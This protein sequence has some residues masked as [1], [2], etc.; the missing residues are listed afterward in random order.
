MMRAGAL[1]LLLSG[2]GWAGDDRPRSPQQAEAWKALDRE[3]A[4]VAKKQE[5]QVRA[6][7]RRILVALQEGDLEVLVD[8]CVMYSANAKERR[9]LTR[10][11]FEEHAAELKAAAL[12][13][14]V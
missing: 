8:E 4:D 1:L 3:F 5:K 9:A 2:W 7:A 10:K 13:A 11:Y 14:D 6:Y 12:L